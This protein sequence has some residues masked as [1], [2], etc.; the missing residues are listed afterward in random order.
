MPIGKYDR[1]P[2]I[3]SKYIGKRFGRFIVLDL[4]DRIPS[5]RIR[6]VCK[7]DCGSIKQVSAGNLNNGRS[8]SCGCLM[9]EMASERAT[10]RKS[11]S[12]EWSAWRNMVQR[13]TKPTNKSYAYYGG[14][15]I[16]VCDDW[17]KFDNFW[18]DMGDKPSTDYQIDR[19]DNN[20]GYF[21]ENCR[22]TA[23]SDNMLNRRV[24]SNSTTGITGVRMRRK[25]FYAEL[26]INGVLVLSKTFNTIEEAIK[27]RSDA[28]KKHLAQQSRP[29]G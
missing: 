7:C 8:Q 19:I 14:R 28:E 11:Y 12:P 27:A 21:K 25:K 3:R 9:R 29:S 18:R 4:G 15:G 17:L 16:T 20:K 10:H 24:F 5:G 26:K 22:W 6:L 1:E 13:C 2:A 23:R